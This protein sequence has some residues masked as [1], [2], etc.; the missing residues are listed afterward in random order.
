[1]PYVKWTD[2]EKETV[3]MLYPTTCLEDLAKKMGRST[4]SVLSMAKYLKIYKAWIIPKLSLT[5]CERG[6]VAGTMDSDGT[7]SIHQRGRG[8]YRRYGLQSYMGVLN[9]KPALIEWLYSKLDGRRGKRST[10]LVKRA[11]TWQITNIALCYVILKEI[12]PLL[13]I[14]KRQ[15]ELLLEFVSSRLN[16][17]PRSPYEERD[18]EIF[19][20]IQTL[21]KKGPKVR[22]KS[23]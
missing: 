11:Y 1:M 20:E 12:L 4:G 10:N 21:N 15:G 17:P 14:K 13:V 8:R 16:K 7:I 23:L 9:T 19:K 22:V 6:Y 3:R 2:E 18:Y 5:D